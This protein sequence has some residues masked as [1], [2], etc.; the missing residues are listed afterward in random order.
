MKCR[1]N[2]CIQ[3]NESDKLALSLNGN[4]KK[5]ISNVDDA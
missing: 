2:K 3:C 5:S 4:K 1:K